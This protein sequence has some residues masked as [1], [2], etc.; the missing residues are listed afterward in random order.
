MTDAVYPELHEPQVHGP[1]FHCG[2]ETHLVGVV[3]SPRRRKAQ[4][5]CFDAP[6]AVDLGGEQPLRE[7]PFHRV[8]CDRARRG[9]AVTGVD[10][11]HR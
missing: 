11:L 9:E 6:F 2:R 7:F 4:F 1:R 8:A 10:T 3:D 5:T